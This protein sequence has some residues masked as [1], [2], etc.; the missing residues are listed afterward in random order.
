M[1]T[2]VTISLSKLNQII[3]KLASLGSQRKMYG[4]K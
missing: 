3:N 2:N 4:R 1:Y